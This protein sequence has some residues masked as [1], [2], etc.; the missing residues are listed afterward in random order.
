[1]KLCVIYLC[2]QS[3]TTYYHFPVIVTEGLPPKSLLFNQ[4]AL[5]EYILIC[6][7]HNDGGLIDKPGK[8]RDVYHTCYTLSGLSVAQLSTIYEK[9]PII[10]S[11]DNKV[12]CQNYYLFY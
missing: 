6:C 3:L 10:G 9:T 8:Q 5:Q 1:M 12:V 7:Q 11:S 2:F 4:T